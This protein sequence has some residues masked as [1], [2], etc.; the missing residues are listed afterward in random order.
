MAGSSRHFEFLA[1][2]DASPRRHAPK[3]APGTAQVGDGDRAGESS[4]WPGS[5]LDAAGDATLARGQGI[6]ALTPKGAASLQATLM[7]NPAFDRR[8]SVLLATPNLDV[9]R[10]D[11][12][13]TGVYVTF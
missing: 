13:K 5:G 9:Y 3:A 2:S 4:V 10:Y 8:T 6:E 7:L 11:A 12:P 1:G